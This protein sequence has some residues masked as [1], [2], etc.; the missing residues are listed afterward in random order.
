MLTAALKALK[1]LSIYTL[2]YLIII[3]LFK[4]QL[5][6]FCHSKYVLGDVLDNYVQKFEKNTLSC[7]IIKGLFI[8]KNW[9]RSTLTATVTCNRYY[10]LS[11]GAGAA[12]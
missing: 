10:L 12:L 4:N 8:N 11:C 5:L 1:D 9:Y 7:L 6:F 2:S 3:S